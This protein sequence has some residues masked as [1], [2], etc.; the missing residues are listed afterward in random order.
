MIPAHI[1]LTRRAYHAAC[2]ACRGDHSIAN[3]IAVRAAHR[4]LESAKGGVR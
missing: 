3:T 1:A 2:A 4:A